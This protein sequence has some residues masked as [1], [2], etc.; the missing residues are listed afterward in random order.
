MPEPAPTA[1]EEAL[2][3]RVAELDRLVCGRRWSPARQ[4]SGQLIAGLARADS[5]IA[6]RHAQTAR[7]IAAIHVR[8]TWE[9]APTAEHIRHLEGAF[10]TALDHAPDLTLAE[11]LA[12]DAHEPPA[13]H[14]VLTDWVRVL[15]DW[16]GRWREHQ[17]ARGRL[18]R[19][20]LRLEL[21]AD[22]LGRLAAQSDE[23][24]LWLA[25]LDA[26][27]DEGRL[28]E[29]LR[30]A[31][32]GS[33]SLYWPRH[34]LQLRLREG[35]VAARLGLEDQA[36]RAWREVW[37]HRLCSA[38]LCMVW[39]AAGPA[40]RPFFA[41]ELEL[42]YADER[43]LQADLQIRLE[44]LLGDA[45]LPLARLQAAEKRT[46]WTDHQHPATQVLPLLLRLGTGQAA[47]DEALLTAR[48]WRATDDDHRWRPRPPDPVPPGW[49]TL[50]DQV[51][52]EH[53]TWLIDAV[54][55]RVAAANVL[56]ELAGAVLD[57]RA[58]G[59][60]LKVAALLVALVEAGTAAGDPA[61]EAPLR[62]IERRFPRHRALLQTI[63][64]TRAFSP[65]LR[66]GRPAPR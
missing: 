5:S 30:A 49:S 16:G 18:Q 24:D 27:Q 36:R 61:A 50:V 15:G 12:I 6:H 28:A 64:Q 34:R 54:A 56:V 26:L 20:A 13:R 31:T 19:E 35:A 48:I 38:G 37:R 47:L 66:E 8:A 42:A 17:V 59:A 32:A 46:W 23:L 53:P 9:S 52:L 45:E 2:V 3:E 60:Y 14:E 51:I 57:A 43:P 33:K 41:E 39:Q 10:L 40:S 11:V 65:L 1:W 7:R 29:A 22:G 21:G 62:S 63:D 55:W 25:W 4:A 58:R 44:V